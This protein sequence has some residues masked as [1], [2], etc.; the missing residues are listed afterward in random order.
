MDTAVWQASKLMGVMT[1][2]SPSSSAMKRIRET[3]VP[4]YWSWPSLEG[5]TKTV[6]AKSGEM[7]T[8]SLPSVTV[9]SAP[10]SV[11]SSFFPQPVRAPA[12]MAPAISRASQFFFFIH[13]SPIYCI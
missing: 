13:H 5:S 11:S 12:S 9:F 3:S 10:S 1:S 7:A 4:T 8:V 2:S 6:G